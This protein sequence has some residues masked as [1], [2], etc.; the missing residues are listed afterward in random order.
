MNADLLSIKD[1]KYKYI[2][3]LFDTSNLQSV[4]ETQYQ[5]QSLRS[6]HQRLNWSR[7]DREINLASQL[8]KYT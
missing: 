6:L 8:Y 2:L 7:P 1:F 5:M 3:T 4:G